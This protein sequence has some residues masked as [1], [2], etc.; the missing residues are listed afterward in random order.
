M[1]AELGMQP[2]PGFVTIPSAETAFANDG[3]LADP[4]LAESLNGLV[5]R[6]LAAIR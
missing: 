3:H 1:V 6:L 5:K 4:G 2:V